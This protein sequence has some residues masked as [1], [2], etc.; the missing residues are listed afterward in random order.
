M[1]LLNDMR[2]HNAA[3]IQDTLPLRMYSND[4]GR[5]G[6]HG[7]GE[8]LWL[9]PGELGKGYYGSPAEPF[10]FPLEHQGRRKIRPVPQTVSG[11]ISTVSSVGFDKHHI[12]PVSPGQSEDL[13]HH[14]IDQSNEFEMP[15]FHPTISG[16]QKEVHV[17]P[18]TYKRKKP[19][20]KL[21]NM[22]SLKQPMAIANSEPMVLS[23]TDRLP[24]EKTKPIKIKEQSSTWMETCV[25]DGHIQLFMAVNF[26]R[27]ARYQLV[28]SNTRT[29]MVLP[30]AGA[31]TAQKGKPDALQAMAISKPSPLLA[32]PPQDTKFASKNSMTSCER[33][34]LQ[35][36]GSVPGSSGAWR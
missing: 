6:E 5:I 7:N 13:K 34:V 8:N 2:L 11:A 35:Q 21:N 3:E 32:T 33:R 18:I 20:I 25:F 26:S 12:F 14:H 36:N 10:S 24:T 19:H 27:E 4:I 16:V 22:E 29:A 28:T 9:N 1:R 15:P 17:F 23:G 30:E 31:T